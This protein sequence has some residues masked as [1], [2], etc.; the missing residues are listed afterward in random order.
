VLEYASILPPAEARA[1]LAETA[2]LLNAI[3]SALCQ[4]D[5]PY[6]GLLAALIELTG[7]QAEA[8]KPA[9]EEP[10]D[11]AWEE[12][13]VFGGCSARGQTRPAAPTSVPF[14]RRPAAHAG[15]L[16]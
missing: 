9:A 15:D 1:F 7:A 8:V 16:A 3:F 6:A 13:P 12:P 10:L 5:S 2:H 14:V 4:R 11:A